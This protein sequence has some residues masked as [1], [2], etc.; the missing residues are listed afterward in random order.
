MKHF[1]SVPCTREMSGER[2]RTASVPEALA[3]IDEVAEESY[4]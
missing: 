1:D 3:G 2:S 4:Y